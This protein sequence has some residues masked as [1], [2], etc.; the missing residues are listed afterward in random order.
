MYE[1]TYHRDPELSSNEYILRSRQQSH[2]MLDK[3]KMELAELRQ[4]LYIELEFL[5]C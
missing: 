5:L 2:Y 4:V 3:L 1:L